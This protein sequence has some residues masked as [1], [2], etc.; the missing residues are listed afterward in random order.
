MHITH[1]AILRVIDVVHPPSLC[2]GLQG[3]ERQ[4]HK[5]LIGLLQEEVVQ[6]GVHIFLFQRPLYHNNFKL[7]RGKEF[8]IWTGPATKEVVQQCILSP[9][10]IRLVE[11]SDKKLQLS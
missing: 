2:Q 11:Q 8:Y 10:I 3:G 9:S 7:D 4:A 1:L 5:L 6:G